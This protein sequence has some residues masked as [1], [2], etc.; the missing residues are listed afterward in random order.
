[1]AAAA[2]APTAFSSTGEQGT[3]LRQGVI[4]S[5]QSGQN[6]TSQVALILP[7]RP[8]G[9]VYGGVLTYSASSQFEAGLLNRVFVDGDTLSHIKSRYGKSLPNWIDN[10]S[11]HHNLDESAT[12]IMAEIKPDY[13]TSTP[14]FSASIPFVASG[15]G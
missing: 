6:D 9:K 10:A 7:D 12:Q 13:G 8:D 2:A 14:Y 4:S 15:V 11:S 1:M 3:I 5:A